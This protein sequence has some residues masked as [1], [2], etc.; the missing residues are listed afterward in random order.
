MTDEILTKAPIKERIS[1]HERTLGLNQIKLDVPKVREVIVAAESGDLNESQTQVLRDSLKAFQDHL[2]SLKEGQVFS[3]DED[4]TKEVMGSGDPALLTQY[5]VLK[6]KFN[7]TVLEFQ[8]MIQRMEELIPTSEAAVEPEESASVGRDQKIEEARADLLKIVEKGEQSPDLLDLMAK[9][10]DLIEAD[11]QSRQLYL[12]KRGRVRSV[13]AD[14]EKKRVLK[15]KKTLEKTQDEALAQSGKRGMLSGLRRQIART[16]RVVL[17]VGGFFGSKEVRQSIA[18]DREVSGALKRAF[19]AISSETDLRNT[20][21]KIMKEGKGVIG[22]KNN[23]KRK[24]ILSLALF[25]KNEGLVG[26]YENG[27]N[28]EGFW[29][30]EVMD[31]VVEREINSTADI[32]KGL[33]EKSGEDGEFHKYIQRQAR[34]FS[35]AFGSEVVVATPTAVDTTPPDAAATDEAESDDAADGDL[36]AEEADDE[37]SDAPKEVSALDGLDD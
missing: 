24:D 25:L 27:L 8:E 32:L 11:K 18:Q 37:E 6:D 20:V 16:G 7:Q 4:V 29:H 21:D 12:D 17:T 13:G 35:K 19:R 2:V 34:F 36:V 22:L 1:I 14:D 15:T 5:T 9:L 31:E 26:D 10:I 33:Y 3:Q 23:S 30:E 28:T